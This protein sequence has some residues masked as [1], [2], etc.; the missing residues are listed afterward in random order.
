MT[1]FVKF[2]AW[3]RAWR[4]H[5]FNSSDS[6]CYGCHYSPWLQTACFTLRPAD[7]V[8][9][10]Q[11]ALTVGAAHTF[12]WCRSPWI[13]WESMEAP[14]AR[15]TSPGSPLLWAE[16]DWSWPWVP[17][18]QHTLCLMEGTYSLGW[19]FPAEVEVETR[20]GMPVYSYP[21]LEKV[22]S[23]RNFMLRCLGEGEDTFGVFQTPP[24]TPFLMS[25]LMSGTAHHRARHTFG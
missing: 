19:S 13:L 10:R 16:A 21:L 9:I 14:Q 8:L 4:G 15:E 12:S 7:Q 23:C 17:V 24:S 3:S 11:V 1:A 25:W 6:R 5:P 22:F 20:S 18:A 2:L